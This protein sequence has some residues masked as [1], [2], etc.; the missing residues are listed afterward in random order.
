[1]NNINNYQYSYIRYL[2]DILNPH[3]FKLSLINDDSTIELKIKNLNSL[4]PVI[5]ILKLHNKFL[6]N[7]LIDIV[8]IDHKILNSF[9]RFELKYILLSHKY[10]ARIIVSVYLDENEI[11]TSISEVHSASVWMEREIYDLFGIPFTKHYDLR[12]ILTDYGFQGN[13]FKKDFPLNGYVEIRYDEEKQYL[14]YEPIE[15]MQNM[16]YYKFKNPFYK[17]NYIL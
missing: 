6:F 1:M 17:K 2:L 15:L 3:L 4:L 12:R 13:P 16:R 14:I 7:N 9:K 8:C 5:K 10:N 11:S